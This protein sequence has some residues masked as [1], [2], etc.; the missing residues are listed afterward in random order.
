MTLGVENKLVNEAKQE[1]ALTN[2]S[3]PA[4]AVKGKRCYLEADSRITKSIPLVRNTTPV[5]G[6]SCSICHLKNQSALD[7]W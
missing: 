4:M 5:Y 6:L 3:V 1:P 7:T 2:I